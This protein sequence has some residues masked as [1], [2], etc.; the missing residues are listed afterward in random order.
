MPPHAHDEGI[1]DDKY[2]LRALSKSW[3]I[4]DSG[5]ERPST[6]AF[7]DSSF[8]N[9]CFV[10]GEISLTDIHLFL[11]DQSDQFAGEVAFARI[12]VGVIRRAGFIVER[13]PD[14]AAGCTNPNAHV[15]VG[16]TQALGRKQYQNTARNIVKDISL[17]IVRNTLNYV[18]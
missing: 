17:T 8:E 14:E 13:R 12:P 1:T 11:A 6:E 18:P 2:L 9:S 7:T 15:V 4:T 5:R 10:E 3:V 16:P